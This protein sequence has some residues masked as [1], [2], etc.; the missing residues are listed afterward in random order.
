MA[1]GPG[2]RTQLNDSGELT[3]TAVLISHVRWAGVLL[4]IVQAFLTTSP[5]PVW[6]WRGV[7]AASI[8]MAAY[9]L[10]AAFA[11]SLPGRW[12]EATLLLCLVGDFLVCTA[13]TLLTSNDVYST[14]YAVFGLVSIEAAVL[15]RWRGALMFT[16][17]FAVAYGFFYGV[18]WHYFGFPP[19]LS[20]V[21]YRSGLIVMTALFI[22]GIARQSE[23]RRMAAAA[24]EASVRELNQDLEQ[25]VQERT[26]ELEASNEQ[27]AAFSYT[28]AHDLRAPLR[29]IDGFSR[30]LGEE[31]SDL[32]P[33]DV[34]HYLDM[35]GGNAV[36]MGNLIDALLTFSR[37]SRQAIQ[38]RNLNPVEVARSAA[39]KLIAG[40]AGRK[41]EIDITE[42][43]L[44][45]SDPI[46]L[47][48]V[49]ANLLGNA[50][51]FSR[52]R[53]VA[54]VEVG[55]LPADASGKDQPVY[56]VKDFGIG[57]DMKYA[58]KLFGV[59][60]R[61][62]GASEFE[63][64]GAGLAIVRRIVQRHGGQAWAEAEPDK[65]ATFYFTLGE[66]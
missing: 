65:G 48:Q 28:V 53:E 6:G 3:Q 61:L 23:R 59:F 63:G 44:C 33:D 1:V 50:V 24:A 32:S 10:P 25:R 37:L 14:S 56:Y 12:V 17:A 41:V 66:G 9:N 52:D 35:I 58:D 7:F 45:R 13:W 49:Y 26:A 36:D 55:Y 19:L 57:F 20:S 31:R 29:A 60:Q 18:R 51:K 27:L 47:E 22:G 2:I 46:L 16:G 62:H 39:D 30:I 64:T 8:V 42:M 40:L 54:R 38:K 4:G 11:R 15:Y 34:Q 43:P 5:T 21:V